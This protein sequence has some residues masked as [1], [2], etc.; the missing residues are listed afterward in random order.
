MRELSLSKSLSAALMKHNYMPVG[1]I[2]RTE[3]E[4]MALIKRT[5]KGRTLSGSSSARESRKI[6]DAEKQ[7]EE[8]KDE[9]K[10][11]EGH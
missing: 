8:G 5:R 6:V 4:R 1:V 11:E 7:E 2:G 9:E 3:M 10:D